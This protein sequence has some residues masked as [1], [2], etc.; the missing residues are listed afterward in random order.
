MSSAQPSVFQPAERIRVFIADDHRI[1]LWGLTRLVESSKSMQVVG[2]ACSRGELLSNEAASLADVLL[3]D[4]D[5]AGENTAE[6]LGTLRER[7]AG[8]F[9]VL[10]G[11]D[12]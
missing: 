11:T 12:D 10:T 6:S 1:T 7:C 2:T 9:L 4:L 3:L 8:R 5:L